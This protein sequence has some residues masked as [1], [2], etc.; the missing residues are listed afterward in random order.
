MSRQKFNQGKYKIKNPQKY[1][2]DVSKCIY[3]SSWER[4]LMIKFDTSPSIIKWGSEVGHIWYRSPIDNQK[5][6]YF[7]DF[8]VQGKNGVIKLIEVK[9]NKECFK[10]RQKKN[11]KTYIYEAKTYITNQAKWRAARDYALE[12]GWVFVVLTEKNEYTP[13]QVID[14]SLDIKY[15]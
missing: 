4:S 12:K 15:Y 2:G 13:E 14:E 6:R 1:I 7:P 9:P 10:P 3:R 5:H 11:K 8:I